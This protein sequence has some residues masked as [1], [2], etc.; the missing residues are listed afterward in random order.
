M[1][2]LKLC[3]NCKGGNI[4]F[5]LP[6]RTDPLMTGNYELAYHIIECQDCNTTAQGFTEEE[7]I[8]RWNTRP[9]EDQLCAKIETLKKKLREICEDVEIQTYACPPNIECP[10]PHGVKDIPCSDCWLRSAGLEK[11]GGE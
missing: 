5:P 11:D 10:D 2:E 1:Q 4:T 6:V 7:C 8:T 3:P 9:I